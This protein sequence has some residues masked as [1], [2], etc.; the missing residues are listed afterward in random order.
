MYSIGFD[1]NTGTR[2]YEACAVTIV[3]TQYGKGAMQ[4][5]SCLRSSKREA[6]PRLLP[7]QPT[8][9]VH[10]A[11]GV[12]RVR[13]LAPLLDRRERG[14]HE[15]DEPFG[16]PSHRHHLD[17]LAPTPMREQYRVNPLR[18]D[19][20]RPQLTREV[21][22]LGR[23]DVDEVALD[24]RADVGEPGHAREL[25]GV[26]YLA[27][28]T[29][30]LRLPLSNPCH[31]LRNGRGSRTRRRRPV[32]GSH[33]HTAPS[34]CKALLLGKLVPPASNYNQVFEHVRLR[35]RHQTQD[36]LLRHLLLSS[37]RPS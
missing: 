34:S 8:A 37:S 14:G 29:L 11:R 36:Q 32:K 5:R 24:R 13:N 26:V 30:F 2:V 4:V 22:S 17:D 28:R 6:V 19:R 35:D 18:G 33:N 10:K 16:Q 31:E 7:L 21:S 20:G 23:H 25:L 1:F 9:Y 12:G 15:R 3:S 27:V